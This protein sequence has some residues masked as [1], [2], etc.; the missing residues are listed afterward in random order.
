M[1]GSCRERSAGA[2][3]NCDSGI[4]RMSDMWDHDSLLNGS[5]AGCRFFPDVPIGGNQSLVL[6]PRSLESRQAKYVSFEFSDIES[7]QHE[8]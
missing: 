7:A 3:L 2:G 1:V 6:D 5:H 4:E 8:C